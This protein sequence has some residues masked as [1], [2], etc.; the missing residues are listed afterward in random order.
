MGVYGTLGTWSD[1]RYSLPQART[2]TS[3]AIIGR[4]IYLV[5]G[6]DG[7]SATNSV[8]RAE[9]LDPL[10]GP[11]VVDLDAALGD[12]TTGLG[13]GM[14]YYKVAAVFPNGDANNPGGESLPG[15]LLTVQLPDRSD[16]II[17][18]LTWDPVPGASGYRIYRTAA[19]DGD[20]NDLQLLAEVT[21]G[22]TTKY[23]DDGQTATTAGEVPLPPGSLGQWREMT[24]SAL[25]T[26][27]AKL[28]T[29]VVQNPSDPGQ[30]YLYAFGGH[31]ASGSVLDS[32]EWARIDVAADGT[33]TMT[34]WTAGSRTIGTPKE[35]LVAWV[36]TNRE[37]SELNGDEA[38]VFVGTGFGS[39]GQATGEITSGRLDATS[40]NGNLLAAATGT[41][42][43]ENGLSS[44]RGGAVGA[45]ANGFL[46]IMGGAKNAL[47]GNDQSTNILPGPDLDDWNGLG[48]GTLQTRRVYPA[49]AQE[50]AFFFVAGGADGSG[51]ALDSV[52]QTVR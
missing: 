42:E 6:S 38:Y 11:D 32:Y 8:Y 2:F 19:A 1:Q 25:N 26:A 29:A 45:A 50:S 3:S 33:Q 18:T 49:L 23:T 37:S 27:R 12:G 48:D 21:D 35:G 34:G 14:W 44:G 13:G 10:A 36:V 28:A 20:S 15:E 16:K 9:I 52:E 22:T 5:G 47:T 24:D 17:L 51:N 31:D 7:T 41:L 40:T 39:N 4:Y 43:T 30:Y 46:F